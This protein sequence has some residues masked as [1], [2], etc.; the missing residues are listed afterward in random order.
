MQTVRTLYSQIETSEVAAPPIVLNVVSRTVSAHV[1]GGIPPTTATNNQYVLLAA[2]PEELRQRVIT[3][4][5]MA[6]AGY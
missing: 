5:Q 1:A 2:L 4:V 3:A 6:E